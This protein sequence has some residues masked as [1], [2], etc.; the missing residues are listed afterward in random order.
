MILVDA[1]VARSLDLVRIGQPDEDGGLMLIR[2]AVQRISAAVLAQPGDA[3][4]AVPRVHQ[5]VMPD[6]LGRL[7]SPLVRVR[8][9]DVSRIFVLVENAERRLV[10]GRAEGLEIRVTR[11]PRHHLPAEPVD[12]QLVVHVVI[13]QGIADDGRIARDVPPGIALQARQTRHRGV[14]VVR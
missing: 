4:S 3:A 11:D 14:R 5:L 7:L 12:A 9:S 8:G 2:L 10:V 13:V 6:H 1:P